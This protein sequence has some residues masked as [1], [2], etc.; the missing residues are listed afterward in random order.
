M[1][2][3]QLPLITPF[4]HPRSSKLRSTLPLVLPV[5]LSVAVTEPVVA[6]VAA[7][8]VVAPLGSSPWMVSS[9]MLQEVRHSTW[10]WLGLVGSGVLWKWDGDGM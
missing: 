10:H 7:V 6:A 8:V 5:V 2:S 3:H 4:H 1:C 9:R